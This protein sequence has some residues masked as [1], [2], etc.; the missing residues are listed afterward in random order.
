MKYDEKP[1][2][3]HKENAFP[4][5][6][7]ANIEE[8]PLG[9]AQDGE[10]TLTLTER[11]SSKH[12]KTR[13]DAFVDLEKQIL[14]GS[15]LPE[16]LSQ[17][18]VLFARYLSDTHPGAQEKALN[19]FSAAIKYNPQIPQSNLNDLIITLIEKC[20]TGKNS[21]KTKGIEAILTIL[22][23][24]PQQSIINSIKD[25]IIPLKTPKIVVAA[26]QAISTIVK[27]FGENHVM[28]KDFLNA[29]E[30]N[31]ASSTNSSVRAA[32]ML[33]YQEAYIW[34]KE[35]IMPF[36]S[37]LKHAQ[38]EDLKKIFTEKNMEI[39]G[40]EVKKEEAKIIEHA[41]LVE[42]S[43]NFGQNWCNEILKLKKWS[44]KKEKLDE[45]LKSAANPP[46]TF[47]CSCELI[48][49]LK[50]L[51]NDPNIIV[52]NT[53]LK[54]ISQLATNLKES[55]IIFHKGLIKPLFQHF[56]D[57]KSVAEAEKCLENMSIS[58]K[59]EDLIEE[60]KEGLLDKSIAIRSHTCIWLEKSIFPN[61]SASTVKAIT[62][63]GL[64][65]LLLKLSDEA[66]AEVRDAALRCIGILKA[67]VGDENEM[68]IFVTDLNQQK[69]EKVKLAADLAK[70]KYGN[71]W[72]KSIENEFEGSKETMVQKKVLQ[73][74]SVSPHRIRKLT[75]RMQ[76]AKIPEVKI[77][78]PTIPEIRP[79]Q[80]KEELIV[81]NQEL[82]ISEEDADK[83]IKQNVPESI[84]ID[85]NKTDWKEREKALEN[86]NEWIM[87][88]KEAS[89]AIYETII[90][91]LRYKLK[92]FKET[93]QAIIRAV[94]TVILSLANIQPAS[95]NF[96]NIVIPFLIEKMAESKWIDSCS[97]IVITI[98]H[99]AIISFV[100]MKILKK[101]EANTKNL[102]LVK[103][104]INML[105]R[106]Y[107]IYN[108]NAFP[109][110]PI[111]ECGKTY[112]THPNQSVRSSASA[113]LCTMYITLGD[114]LKQLLGDL[115]ECTIKS[116][117]AQFEKVQLKAK[118]ELE[119][120]MV[121]TQEKQKNEI[122]Q[123]DVVRANISSQITPELISSLS[124]ASVKQRQ[125]AKDQIE[126]I[127]LNS[128]NKIHTN[129]LGP[130][131][132]AL[133]GR[134]SEPCKSLG[135][136]FIELVGNLFC[137]MDIGCKQYSKSIL[138]E[139]VSNLADKQ[140]YIRTEA[141]IA[142]NKISEVHGAEIII[143]AVGQLIGK[144][145]SDMRNEL[146]QWIIK[147]K[148]A[149]KNTENIQLIPGLMSCLQDKSADIRKMAEQLVEI[150]IPIIGT[151]P[152][153]IAI[154]DYK[155]IAKEK[156]EKII[157]KY[158]EASQKMEIEP[159]ASEE[160]FENQIIEKTNNIQFKGIEGIIPILEEA[161]PKER[162]SNL[163]EEKEA[164]G[165]SRKS[166]DSS[167]SASDNLQIEK[168]FNIIEGE[169]ET[170]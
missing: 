107:E 156:I 61:A 18:I 50:I 94:L 85:I 14:A 99:P 3:Q 82:K 27:E 170:S 31:A 157:K 104:G 70:L 152:F 155:P 81:N 6:S 71:K 98:S 145:S 96:A 135:K 166:V 120:A 162:G 21:I 26:L 119:N 78:S 160:K 54:I 132:E 88:N 90:V 97:N 38:Q 151:Q 75:T 164:P 154:Q 9:H 124:D 140:S 37:N 11:L 159:F 163:E 69:Q 93:N 112:I 143:N 95:K 46:P 34:L 144:E 110:A 109:L 44:E 30:K 35:E 51:L 72:A 116:L 131:L 7:S 169:K 45:L 130:L 1:I 102:N 55:F 68:Q 17:Q 42:G 36:I 41:E 165:K 113:L 74:K 16:T 92:D 122:R 73:R 20:L 138:Q 4:T 147:K 24:Y 123:E 86:L 2:G 40:V 13:L 48:S 22:K 84:S 146:L 129:G 121:D 52:V 100:V 5:E 137:A 142:M 150:L 62:N 148:D 49:T 158:S 117:E 83:I 91:W 136:D 25:L 12:W 133:K 59:F 66:T 161:S 106:M 67:I 56:K 87:N 77:P 103:G 43:D 167:S 118:P 134:M 8:Q 29:V 127:L 76:T 153:L 15:I 10:E 168:I 149:L 126:K 23:S 19:A 63:S 32:A 89:V 114:K 53:V 39:Q 60:V 57:K 28:V 141:I 58:M 80:T 64:L 79:I 105:S 47:K 65:K 128:G 125:K 139:L 33:V 108:S 115:Q 111:V 101:I